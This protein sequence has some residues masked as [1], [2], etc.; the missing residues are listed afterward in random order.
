MS[1]ARRASRLI[2]TAAG[3]AARGWPEEESAVI[4]Q[5]VSLALTR[6]ARAS[7]GVIRAAVLP[8]VSRTSRSSRAAIVAASSSARAVTTVSPPRPSAIGSSPPVSP[9]SRSRSIWVSQ[10]AVESGGRR[11][12]LI[13]RRRQRPAGSR[14]AAESHARTALRSMPARVSNR[15]I[16]PCGWDSP[17]SRQASSA[18]STSSPGSTTAPRG[19]A[20]M[21]DSRSA[22][23]GAE[24][25]EPAAIITSAGGWSRQRSASR[26][27]SATRRAA[28]SIIPSSASR[29]GQCPVAI[30]RNAADNCQW[31]ASSP[32]TRASTASGSSRS[33]IW[34]ASR[35]AARA[36]AS[37]RAEPASRRR[38]SSDWCSATRPASSKRRRSGEIA[39][40]RSRARSPASNGGSPSSRSPRA[41]T[42]GR[43]IAR[44]PAAFRKASARSR[45]ERRVGSSTTA[46]ASASGPSGA[47]A[48]QIPAARSSRNGLCAG[49]VNQRGP[50]ASRNPLT[51]PWPAGPRPP[52]ARRDRRHASTPRPWSPRADGRPGSS[53]ATAAGCHGRRPASRR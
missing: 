31:R 52:P 30:F 23:A 22:P 7:S 5:R 4:P 51:A 39:G 46:S 44:A 13:S 1:P 3:E 14:V 53:P 18:R 49:M 9:S 37:S 27:I 11:A 16:V 45:A 20:A 47:R 34:Q 17:T 10:S 40:G 8:G 36:S 48:R 24:P 6:R 12:S 2:S 32:S 26:R 42:C 35:K 21:A 29:R 43:I 25:V 15:F 33:S 28:T 50:G 19:A 38:S 41:R